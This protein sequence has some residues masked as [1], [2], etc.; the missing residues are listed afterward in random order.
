MNT[1]SYSGFRALMGAAGHGLDSLLTA[2]IEAG[3]DVNAQDEEYQSA[4]FY[5]AANGKSSSLSLL[6]LAGADV[7]QVINIKL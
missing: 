6:A 2:L 5:A 4:L 1:R 3:A 7:K